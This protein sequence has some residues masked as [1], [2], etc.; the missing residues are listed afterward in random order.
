MVRPKQKHILT[1]R[2][3]NARIYAVELAN[4]S[5][6]FFISVPFSLFLFVILLPS[7]YTYLL[8]GADSRKPAKKTRTH[9]SISILL[10]TQ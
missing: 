6:S 4:Q 2:C 8:S 5:T 3:T 10:Q 1:N 9:T 7:K